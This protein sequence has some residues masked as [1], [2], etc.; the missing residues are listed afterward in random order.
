MWPSKS[1]PELV[2]I[3][4]S[5]AMDSARPY[6]KLCANICTSFGRGEGA[7]IGQTMVLYFDGGRFI[8][9]YVIEKVIER[10]FGP[11]CLKESLWLSWGVW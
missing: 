3:S 5:A 1:C 9:E 4:K 8:F 11:R 7:R 6:I 10:F 2:T